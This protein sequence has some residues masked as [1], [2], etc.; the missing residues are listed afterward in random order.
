MQ[1][2]HLTKQIQIQVASFA[3]FVILWCELHVVADVLQ[4]ACAFCTITG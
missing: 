4:F 1:D 3:L 2:V